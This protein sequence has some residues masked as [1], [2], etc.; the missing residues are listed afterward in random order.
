M[1]KLLWPVIVLLIAG[2]A[3]HAASNK[4]VVEAEKYTTIAPSMVKG[5]DASASKG[6]YIGIPLARPH[7]TTEG[8]PK[9][10]GRATYKVNIP[11][12]G[13]W[14]FWARTKWT[15]GCGNSF[16]LKI[17]SKP[18][19]DLGQDGTYGTWHWVKGPSLSLPAGTVNVVI[20]NREDGAKI[21]QFIFTKDTRYVPV[22]AEK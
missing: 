21:D 16:F 8:A 7:A 12:A 14:R 20:Q 15:D 6:A 13:T 4:V 19:V 22:R 5:T 11:S 17:G 2:A 1:K 18:Q 3:L 9:D 10:Q